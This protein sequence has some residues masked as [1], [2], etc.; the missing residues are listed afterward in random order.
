MTGY[1]GRC[2][3]TRQKVV[4]GGLD[5]QLRAGSEQRLWRNMIRAKVGLSDQRKRVQGQVEGL[6]EEMMIKLSGVVSDLFGVSGAKDLKGASG[7]GGGSGEAG[8]PGE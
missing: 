6:L 2:L 7:W 8:Q 5:P 4:V 3:L 1:D